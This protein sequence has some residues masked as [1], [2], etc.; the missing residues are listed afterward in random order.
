MNS[1]RTKLQEGNTLG[2]LLDY[3]RVAEMVGVRERSLPNFVCLS[4]CVRL[5]LLSSV[6]LSQFLSRQSAIFVLLLPIF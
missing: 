3:L 6:H 4:V 2:A 1:A 5:S